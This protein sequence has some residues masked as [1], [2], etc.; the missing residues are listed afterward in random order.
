MKRVLL[1]GWSELLRHAEGLGFDW[2]YAHEIL[3]VFQ[4]YDNLAEVNCEGIDEFEPLGDPYIGLDFKK[5][6]GDLNQMG[7]DIVFD[8]MQKHK[9][10]ERRENDYQKAQPDV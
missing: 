3:R 7:R 4:N 1:V 2:N 9:I 5:Q 6:P 10:T 8:F